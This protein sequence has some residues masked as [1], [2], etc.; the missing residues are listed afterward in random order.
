MD[1]T[2]VL[3]VEDNLA[4]VVLLMELLQDTV[5][6]RWQVSHAKRLCSALEQLQAIEFDVILLDLSLPDSQGLNTVVQVQAAAP[7]IPIVVLT[8]LQDM[9]LARQAVAQGAQ[10]YLVKGQLSSELLLKAVEYAIERIQILKKLQDNE[11]RFRGVFN[12]TFQFMTLLSPS[13]VILDINQVVREV[14]G[15]SDQVM[16]DQLIWEAPCYHSFEQ[17]QSWLK[18]A[19]LGTA[20]REIM[21]SELQV[22]TAQGALL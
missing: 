21:R 13:G 4:D 3:L 15:F 18:G 10:D 19:I 1:T 16:I 7:Q 22:C 11:R 5:A 6:E 9:T 17:S 8:G 2:T 12:Q 14:I 20:H